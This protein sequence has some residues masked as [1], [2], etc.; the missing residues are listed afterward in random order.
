MAVFHSH[1]VTCTCGGKVTVQL[2]DSVN[3][4]RS[5]ELRQRIVDGT[6]HRAHCAA[7]GN[8]F[9][10]ERAFYYVDF[11]QNMVVRVA[12]RNERHL[13]KSQSGELDRAAGFLPNAISTRDDRV[14]RVVYGMDELREKLIAQN[15][16]LDD[17]L[18][19][20]LKMYV[21]YD[22]PILLRKPRLRLTLTAMSDTEAEFSAAYEHSPESFQLQMPMAKVRDLQAHQ[23]ELAD[24]SR[25]ADDVGLFQLEDH[26]V[27]LWRW[28]PQPAA[29]GSL[30]EFAQ[31][32]ETNEP[33]DLDGA[34]FTGMLTGLPRG[35]HLPTWAKQ[36]LRTVYEYVKAAGRA[37]L[38]DDLFEIRFG[39]ELED[40][41]SRNQDADDIDALWRLL[42]DLPDSNVEGN[43]RIRQLL[44]DEG[45]GGGWYSPSTHDIAIGSRNLSNRSSFENV[46]RHEI[47]HAVHEMQTDLVNGWLE[48]T[49]GWRI[50][51][52]N[53]ADIDEWVA[54]MGGW[55][56]LTVQQRRDVRLALRTALGGG[57]SWEPG[58]M[59]NLPPS[60]P[61]NRPNFGPRLAYENS[62]ANWYAHHPGWYRANGR[63]FYLNYWYQTLMV[64]N[65]DT[66]EQWVANM[67][68]DYAAMSHFEFF[69]ELYALYYDPQDPRRQIVTPAV[70]AWLDAN[71]GAMELN[72]PRP[73][74][75]RARRDWEGTTRPS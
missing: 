34:K 46:V 25:V 36:D 50:F 7:C 16:G 49:F 13:W 38:E 6:L 33:V 54:L 66:L 48:D 57:S 30:R 67:P 60:H 56:D 5:P 29:L 17:R 24:Y 4:A 42:K 74:G 65:A 22:H 18:V 3:A 73:A 53:D 20:M 1:K 72:A 71:I 61:W 11:E 10:V 43:T 31:A 63:A 45:K 19:E 32:I 8:D 55:G 47:A 26:W 15:A 51:G 64:V 58:P 21:L 44:L 2:A 12:P 41:W 75:P 68:D 28:S 40:D 35:N 70:Q 23:G 52:R 37:A 59:P 69:A 27:N 14:L 62:K 39:F 9:T